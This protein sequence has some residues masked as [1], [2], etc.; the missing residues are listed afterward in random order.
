MRVFCCT[1]LATLSIQRSHVTHE[2]YR[3]LAVAVG[4]SRT[5]NA[6]FIDEVGPGILDAFVQACRVRLLAMRLGWRRQTTEDQPSSPCAQV[7]FGSNAT[8]TQ[9]YNRAIK[10]AETSPADLARQAPGPWLT[11]LQRMLQLPELSDVYH[12][13]AHLC[14]QLNHPD[15]ALAWFFLARDTTSSQYA[16]QRYQEV[17]RIRE[18]DA[19]EK[20]IKSCNGACFDRALSMLELL[21][22]NQ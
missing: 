4:E 2:G 3:A 8:Q 6:L 11:S 9:Q 21:K 20:L 1:A 5:L 15:W 13:M 12:K 7:H 18:R 10:Q 17:N 22:R 16:A 19:H 14:T